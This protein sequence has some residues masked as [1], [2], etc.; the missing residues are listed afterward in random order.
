MAVDKPVQ[1]KGATIVSSDVVSFDGG[2][3]E[4]GEYNITPNCFSFGRNAMVNSAGNAVHR[5]S[6]K[7]WL[8]SVTACNSE[9]ATVYYNNQ[10]YYFVADNGKMKYC[11]DNSTSW[12]D[13]GGGATNAI[14]TT[15]G[16][17]TTF[18]RTNNWLLCMNGVDELRY[19]DLATFAMTQ[20][21]YVPNPI[22]AIT[23]AA[24]GI[25]LS[26]SFKVYYAY[27]YSSNGGGE[28]A[29]SPIL[30]QTVSKSRSTWIAASEYLTLTFNDTPPAGATSRNLYAAIA[31]QGAAPVASDLALLQANIPTGQASFVDNGSL[32]FNI[33]FNLA[34]S[35]NSTR[36]IKAKAGTIA[37]NVPVLYGDPDNPYNLYFGV[38]TATGVSFG[39]NNG[40]QTLPLLKGTDYY[41]IAVTGFRNNQNVPNLLALFSGTK[42]VSRQQIISQKTLTYGNATINYWGSDELNVGAAA[43]YS[44]YGVVT[45]LNELIFPA[46]DGII[47]IKTDRNLQLVLSPSIISIPI[48]TTY[49]TIKNAQFSKI[50]ST[51][52]NNHV[53]LAIPSQGYNYN[54]QIAVYDLNNKDKPKWYVW[55]L[56]AEWIGTISPPDS[57]SFVYIRQG[58][59]FFKLQ[60]SYVAEDETPTG[61]STPYPVTINGSLKPFTT[62]RNS[63]FALTQAVL[64]LANFI[65]SVDITFSYIDKKG[66]TKSKTKTFT[67][68]TNQRNTTAGWGNPRLGW[69]SGNSRMINW[70]KQLPISGESSGSQKAIKRCR[71]RLPNPVVNEVKFSIS[72]NLQNTS[73]DLVY[74]NYEGVNIGVIGDIV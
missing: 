1:V 29:I 5:L 64:Y 58:G 68:G 51:A 66:K 52:W 65:G 43:V 39:A 36:G 28:T 56:P 10:I 70:S 6:K 48:S 55:D 19:I 16:V 17:I 40:G 46:T 21:T 63:F 18:M 42:G 61:L 44:S 53:L 67:N 23:A 26:G 57:P 74:G 8:P 71:I 12:T 33:A 32:P 27:T 30:S 47:S 4:R 50:V 60:E 25:T 2:L 3:D 41:P 13:C 62:G 14:T 59:D 20:F 72:S 37:G 31:L 34:P 22:P 49:G 7:K 15:P 9:V 69:K 35:T 38:L 45:Y 11:Q 24:T 73:F 54:N